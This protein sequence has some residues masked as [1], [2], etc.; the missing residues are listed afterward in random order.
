MDDSY[1]NSYG[2][3]MTQAGDARMRAKQRTFSLR[4]KAVAFLRPPSQ[5][6]SDCKHSKY[7][8]F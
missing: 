8:N 7:I 5:Q 6:N 3:D 4:A 1:R 2:E